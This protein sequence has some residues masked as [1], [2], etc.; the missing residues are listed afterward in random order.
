MMFGGVHVDR[1]VLAEA[2][3]PVDRE[4]KEVDVELPRLC[5]VENSQNRRCSSEFHT[6]LPP[7]NDLA[8]SIGAKSV[9]ELHRLLGQFLL[10]S[11][12]LFN[13]SPQL[14]H[15]SLPRFLATTQAV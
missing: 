8:I 3:F 9:V 6:R 5:Y 12:S 7:P 11:S 15:C 1:E 10:D 4:S 2:M 14:T 13:S